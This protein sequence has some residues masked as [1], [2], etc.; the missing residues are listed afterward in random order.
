MHA[1]GARSRRDVELTYE[2]KLRMLLDSAMGMDYL[3]KKD[4]IHRDFK[5]LNLLVDGNFHVKVADFG[6][7][8]V[9]NRGKMMTVEIGTPHWTAPEV[10]SKE[11]YTEKADVFSFGCVTDACAPRAVARVLTTSRNCPASPCGRCTRARSHTAARAPRSWQAWL[12]T[13]S[14][15]RSYPPT[16]RRSTASSCSTAGSKMPVRERVRERGA[17]WRT[18]APATADGARRSQTT[19]RRSRRSSGGWRRCWTFT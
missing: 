3:H 4:I 11:A 15:G 18:R 6:L 8:R 7:A 17:R 19:G 12:C 2:R 9:V 16:C 1:D 13:R 14:T 10:L 5:S